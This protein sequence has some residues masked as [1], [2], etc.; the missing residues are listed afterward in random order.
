MTSL[1][2]EKLIYLRNVSYLFFTNVPLFVLAPYLIVQNDLNL[3]YFIYAFFHYVFEG[4]S[5]TAGYHRLFSHKSYKVKPILKVVLL[6]VGAG[7]FQNSA[8]DWAARHRKHHQ[9]CD[10]EDDPYG[11]TK[12][13]WWAHILW[14]FKMRDSALDEVDADLRS[15]KYLVWQ[16]KNYNWL[17]LT[18]GLG[19]PV[20]MG[21][22]FFG[23]ALGGLVWGGLLRLFVTSH[24]TYFINSLAHTLGKREYTLDCTARDNFFAAMLTFGEGYHNF[25][26]KFPS[27]Y[28]S[29]I[30]WFQW[31]PTKWLIQTLSYFGLTFDLKTVSDEKINIAKEEVI[32]GTQNQRVQIPMASEKKAA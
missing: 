11:I 30:K 26:H 18:V 5:I 9:M 24:A 28:R 1:K 7:T 15:D 3:S 10:T 16:Y 32:F 17:A 12:G 29:G 27:D 19:V 13:F 4:L 14:V 23:T 25:H 8:I 21:Y 31:D 22:C 2:A 20:L 6:I